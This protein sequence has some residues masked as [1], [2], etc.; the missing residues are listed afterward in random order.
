MM[1]FSTIKSAGGA[2]GYYSDK[3]NYYVLGSLES[4]WVGEGAKA[5]GLEGRVENLDLTKVLYG[6]LPDGSSLSR[7]VDG[8]ETHRAGYDL[9]FSAP[10]SVSMMALIAG[11]E[12]FVAAHNRAVEIAMKEVEGLASARITDNK[13]MSTELTGNI[14]AALFN[15]DTS[16]DLDPQLHTHALVV[17]ATFA[18]GKWRALASDTK[19]K[20][21]FSET[22][23][24]NQVALGNIYRHALRERVEEMGFKTHDSGRNGLWEMDGVPVESFSQR[25]QSIREAAGEEASLKSRD[26]ATMDT[27]KAK[28]AADPALL[29]AEWEEK[30]NAT[31]FDLRAYQVQ[32]KDREQ[33]APQAAAPS[34]HV[35]SGTPGSQPKPAPGTANPAR[36]VDMQTAVS[37][38]ISLLSDNKVQFTYSDVLAKTVGQLPAEPGVFVA[39]RAGIDRAIEQQALIPLDKEKGIFTSNIH[40]LNE[41]SI[42]TLAQEIKAD[43]KVLT[44]P[45]RATERTRPYSDAVSVLAQDKSPIAVLSGIGGASVQ[46]DR[47]AETVDM[48]KEQGRHVSVLSAD[49]RS[50]AFLAQDTRLTAHL[51]PRSALSAEMSLP[52]QSTLIV[53]QA[54]KLSLKDTLLLLEHAQNQS[55]QLLFMNTEKRKG[56]GN[57]LSVLNEA[58]VN[59]YRYYGSTQATAQVISEP[60][61]RVRYQ[62]LAQEY[63]ALKTA[64]EPVLAQVNG[65]REQQTLTAS[66]RDALREKGALNGED[67]TVNVLQ[68]VWLDSKTRHQ[69]DSYR[70]GMVMERWDSEAKAMTRYTI[71]RVTEMSNTLTLQ[72]AEGNSRVEK[73]SKL[74]SQWSLYKAQTL[75]VAEGDTLQVLGREEKGAL[76]ARDQVQVT[77]VSD[78]GL[79]VQHNGTTFT[80]DTTRALKLSHGYVESLGA[81]VGDTHKVLAATA[82]KD[83]SEAGLNGLARSGESV[84]LYTALPQEKAEARLAGN[85]LFKVAS[86]QVKTLAGRD[87]LSSAMQVQRDSLYTPVEQSVRLGTG[88]AMQEDI[89]FSRLDLV[90]GSLGWTPGITLEAVKAE[91]TRQEKA[92]DLI[93]VSN[94]AL[95]GDAQVKYVTRESYEMEKAILRTIAEGKD[96]VEPLMAAIPA[97]TLDGLTSGQ[98][99]ATTLILNS[100]DRFLAIQGYAGVGKTTQFKAVLGALETLPETERPEVIGLAPTHRAVHEMQDASVKAQTL[101]SFLY[102]TRQKA[103]GGEIVRFDNTVFL[104][105]ESSMIGNRDMADAYKLIAQGNGRAIA[106]GDKAQLQAIDSGAP[107]TLQQ[108]RSVADIAIMKDIVRQT[109][110]LRP[111]IYSMIEGHAGR[112]IGEIRAVTPAQVPREADA[113]V[114]EA[115]VM[116][117]KTPDKANKEDL[118]LGIVGVIPAEKQDTLPGMPQPPKTVIEAITQD[119]TGRTKAARENTLI[120]A[121]LNADRHE[122]NSRVHEELFEK[123]ALGSLEKQV[124][125]LDPVSVRTNELRSAAG[126]AGHRDKTVLLDNT[127][128]SVGNTDLKAGTVMLHDQEGNTRLLSNFENST[129]DISLFEK[130]ELKVSVGD[131]VRFTRSDKERGH[132]ANTL[133]EVKSLDDKHITLT[134]G[135]QEKTLMPQTETADRHID[136]AYAITAHGAQ[137]AS[138]PFVIALEGTEG[139]RRQLATQQGAYVALSRAKEHIQVYTDGLDKWLKQVNDSPS[140]RSAHDVLHEKDDYSR[141][142]VDKLLATAKPLSDTGLGR[143]L[144]KTSALEGD[145]QARFIAP[146]RKYPAP[147]LAL[148]VYDRNGRQ[149]GAYL[150]EIT[151][152]EGGLAMAG[153]PRLIGS[154]EAQFAALQH[155]RGGEVRIAGS[156]EEA[157]TLARQYPDSGILVRLSGEGEPVNLKRIIGGNTV[158]DPQALDKAGKSQ[159]DP[160]PF[161]PTKEVPKAEE[162]AKKAEAAVKLQAAQKPDDPFAA[163]KAAAGKPAQ[164]NDEKPLP[165]ALRHPTHDPMR[166]A[167]REVAK[168]HTMTKRL[169][170]V[171]REIVKE[172]TLGE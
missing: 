117:F 113:W 88:R 98:K 134:N 67:K 99:A 144:L 156:M 135:T 18:E 69:R 76:K 137:G 70:P 100:P 17:N 74:D 105:D 114:P 80:L 169:Y 128:Y 53:D 23:L 36:A 106:S 72:D 19:G 96:S 25:S 108:Q 26:V 46:R 40:L 170:Q 127:Y 63:A 61:K 64:G 163:I 122:I 90:G 84:S 4:R 155:S 138:Q 143:N 147:H 150:D 157:L 101:A 59:R 49:N 44:F 9:T 125:I 7:M 109:P 118:H 110:A 16:R 167:V 82:A 160:L 93:V 124:D 8:K 172:K 86:E 28:V 14:V 103:Q 151:Q 139:G 11:D 166:N 35:L 102:E 37:N 42:H 27:R 95:K 104:I 132:T 152:S 51:L 83:L 87:D 136:L 112:A 92:G 15:H 146:G 111:A 24:G 2:A 31:G 29:K 107:F 65:V 71:D 131:K 120:V 94:K 162:E 50:Q 97:N 119:Y 33:A 22:V 165:D 168:A 158:I 55:V 85:P 45:E 116:E 10:K 56:T 77:G 30:L 164:E 133:W 129:Q 60:D 161:I 153:K 1:S 130:Y 41:L 58:G 73:I 57:A 81:T 38:A 20:S 62:A 123:G 5:L 159:D 66:I 13:M 52:V 12:R 141:S 149:A 78:T 140:R 75:N 39:A 68:P 154:D 48:A 3:D 6:R 171:E 43:H 115:S 79:T 121:H 32:A 91:V 47:L 148:P 145:S 126:W 34:A 54:E 21:G 89:V 142:V